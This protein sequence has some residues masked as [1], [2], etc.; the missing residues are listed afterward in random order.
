MRVG[1]LLFVWAALLAVAARASCSS[2]NGPTSCLQHAATEN[3]NW[4]VASFGSEAM[5]YDNATSHCCGGGPTFYLCPKGTYCNSDPQSHTELCCPTVAA[6]CRGDSDFGP[7]CCGRDEKCH[8]EHGC[9]L[10]DWTPV[11]ESPAGPVCYYNTWTNGDCNG[12]VDRRY[13]L[14]PIGAC[15][16]ITEEGGSVILWNASWFN[17][18]ITVFAHPHCN[19][20]RYHWTESDTRHSCY[21]DG[22]VGW[23][24]MMITC[25]PA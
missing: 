25:P 10:L 7:Y 24:T 16:E 14:A 19:A 9:V 6:T 12:P 3:C 2:Y 15:A 21:N 5:C 17:T 4:C 23:G 8:G 13:T 11:P 20:S 22:L 1:P 18:T